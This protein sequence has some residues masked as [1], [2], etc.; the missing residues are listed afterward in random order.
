MK[1]VSNHFK[2][3]FVYLRSDRLSLSIPYITQ[4]KVK[5]RKKNVI[6]GKFNEATNGDYEKE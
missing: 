2:S 3:L 1:I 6:T 4:I 5:I